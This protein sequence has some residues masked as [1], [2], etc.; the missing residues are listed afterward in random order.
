MEALNSS[1]DEC[2]TYSPDKP[3]H[4]RTYDIING[5]SSQTLIV[6]FQKGSEL[7]ND[8]KRTLNLF[9]NKIK[10]DTRQFQII[11]HT[12]SIGPSDKNRNLSRRRAWN[13]VKY[14]SN[15]GIK[16]NRFQVKGEGSDKPLPGRRKQDRRNRR[17]EIIELR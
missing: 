5:T 15:Y 3:K 1:L 9:A 13:V 12:D 6:F 11:G 16:Q 4:N 7:P 10:D 14:L 8:S 2:N 17:V